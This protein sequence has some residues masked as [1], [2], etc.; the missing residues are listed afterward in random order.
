MESDLNTQ[1]SGNVESDETVQWRHRMKSLKDL[2][3]FDEVR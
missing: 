3:E 1:T 2:D